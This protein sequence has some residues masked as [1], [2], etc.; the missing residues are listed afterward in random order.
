[1]PPLKGRLIFPHKQENDKNFLSR[2]Y[3]IQVPFIKEN[4]R[5]VPGAGIKGVVV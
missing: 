1:M 3:F 2:P 4:P 5:P